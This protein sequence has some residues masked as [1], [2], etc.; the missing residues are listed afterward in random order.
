MFLDEGE[1]TETDSGTE[2]TEADDDDDEEEDET[3]KTTVS[4]STKEQEED[5][6]DEPKTIRYTTPEKGT[7]GLELDEDATTVWKFSEPVSH[8]KSK[9]KKGLTMRKSEGVEKGDSVNED[10]RVET[11]DSPEEEGTEEQTEF[12]VSIKV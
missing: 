10:N 2:S 1:T 12:G 7:T 8:G 9:K 5:R 11:A 4:D 6:N 3:T